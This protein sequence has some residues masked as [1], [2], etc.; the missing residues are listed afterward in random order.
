[1]ALLDRILVTVVKI[2]DAYRKKEALYIIKFILY[3]FEKAQ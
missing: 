2:L 1:M 3:Y